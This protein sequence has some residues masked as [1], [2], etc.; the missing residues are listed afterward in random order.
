MNKVIIKEYVEKNY[1]HK[2]VIR[3][4]L[5]TYEK[6]EIT[7]KNVVKFYETL[8]KQVEVTKDGDKQ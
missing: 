7:Y 2:D 8:K 5:E 1:I 4:I 6:K 3:K